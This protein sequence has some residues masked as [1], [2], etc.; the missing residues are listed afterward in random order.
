[1]AT[2]PVRKRSCHKFMIV[3][4][5]SHISLT[6]VISPGDSS[7]VFSQT[8]F[9]T[10]NFD[11]VNHNLNLFNICLYVKSNLVSFIALS[12]RPFVWL[13]DLCRAYSCS[14]THSWA[15]N[16]SLQEVEPQ[17]ARRVSRPLS[18]SVYSLTSKPYSCQVCAWDITSRVH[19]EASHS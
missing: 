4:P 5:H 2:V 13:V 3:H 19:W 18:Y 14:L 7:S 10:V 12:R 15:V 9:F 1:M 8:F 17:Q 6:K 11:V 16:H